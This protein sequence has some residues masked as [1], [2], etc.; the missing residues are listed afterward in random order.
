MLARIRKSMEE[1]DSGFTL[2]EL[3]VVMII[4]GILAAIAIPTFLRQ[5]ENGWRAAVES[6]LKNAAVAAESYATKNNGS[7][8][9]MTVALLQANEGYNATN[10]VT[11]VEN[12]YGA[13]NTSYC[14]DGTHAQLAGETWAYQSSDDAGGAFDVGVPVAGV[15]CP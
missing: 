7:Y 12:L 4:I 1:R 2:I 14:L 6:D 5:R 8:T 13:G 9:G 15:T 10:D 3:L 11:I